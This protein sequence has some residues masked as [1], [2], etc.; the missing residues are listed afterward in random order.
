MKEWNDVIKNNKL[1]EPYFKALS[2]FTKDNNITENYKN[3]YKQLNFS[4]KTLEEFIEYFKENINEGNKEKEKFLNH[5]NN[6][7]CFFLDELHKLCKNNKEEIDRKIDAPEQDPKK[8]LNLFDNF[9]K[10][11]FSYISENFFGKKLI[12]KTCKT[13]YTTYYLYEY[14]K[15]IPLDIKENTRETNLERCLNNFE[16][17]FESSYFCQM[18]SSHQKCNISIKIYEKPNI[19]I[20]IIT[21]YNKK[22]KIPLYI[23]NNCFKLIAAEVK[24]SKNDCLSSL[25]NFLCCKNPSKYQLLFKDI[26]GKKNL[27]EENEDLKGVPY[28]LF[29][30]KVREEN[31]NKSY[32]Y[33]YKTEISILSLNENNNNKQVDIKNNINNINNTNFD[34]ELINKAKRQNNDMSYSNDYNNI[35]N[36]A[37]TGTITLYFR[38]TNNNKEVYIDTDDTKP[39]TIIVQELKKKYQYLEYSISQ[40]NLIY[41]NKTIDLKKTPKQLDI[42]NESRILIQADF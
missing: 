26:E 16:R 22:L 12:I 41:K 29:Y 10:N 14:I 35:S 34:K 42:K 28:V 19:L 17:K 13:C 1:N 2:F 27:I 36:S 4:Q 23:Y 25:I 33:D 15:V 7:F 18:C 40:N 9:T 6:I 32:E 38:L 5:P 11:D 8:A 31:T 39:F 24:Y 30:K 3:N 37:E 21:N 20:I